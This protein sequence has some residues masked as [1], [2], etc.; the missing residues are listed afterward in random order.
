ML[1]KEIDILIERERERGGGEGERERERE[2]GLGE[3]GRAYFDIL[4][5]LEASF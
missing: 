5:N 1:R 4:K 3:G 2:G